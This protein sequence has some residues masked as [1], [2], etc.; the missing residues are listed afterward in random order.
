MGNLRAIINLAISIIL[1]PVLAHYL[2]SVFPQF[3]YYY[4]NLWS[5]Q[6]SFLEYAGIFSLLLAIHFAL[7]DLHRRSQ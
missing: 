4:Q 7:K 3:M 2:K 5:Y 1:L 6:M